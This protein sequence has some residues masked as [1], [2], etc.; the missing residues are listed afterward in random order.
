M[1]IVII[2]NGVAGMEAALAVRKR[3]PSWEITLISEESDHFFSR[4]ALMWVFSGQ[5]SHRDI[6]PLERDAYQRLS[7]RR[8]RARA[9]GIDIVSRRVSF[10]GGHEPVSYDRLLIASGS[11]PRQGPWPGS[12]ARGVGHFV[13]LQ[14]R[15]RATE[16]AGSCERKHQRLALSF[17][18]GRRGASRSAGAE[19][20]GDRRGSHRDRSHRGCRHSRPPAP[21][22]HP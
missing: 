15:W 16:A 10:A 5:M 21:F 18:G 14:D 20:R 4:T 12:E 13:T 8:V 1:R 6:E 7:F 19:A 11:R 9:T 3:E 22:L 2:G 17:P